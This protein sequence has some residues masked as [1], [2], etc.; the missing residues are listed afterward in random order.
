MIS[1]KCLEIYFLKAVSNPLNGFKPTCSSI[2]PIILRCCSFRPIIPGLNPSN[3]KFLE[4][5]PYAASKIGLPRKSYIWGRFLK[6]RFTVCLTF[7]LQKAAKKLDDCKQRNWIELSLWHSLSKNRTRNWPLVLTS[8]I[9]FNSRKL[10]GKWQDFFALWSTNVD[11]NLNRDVMS[12]NT[13][14][15]WDLLLEASKINQLLSWTSKGLKVKSF[16]PQSC[17]GTNPQYLL[18]Q[19]SHP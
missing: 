11:C 8:L 5:C 19:T 14:W 15:K 2:R 1:K 9:S 6:I 7:S 18:M 16:W 13:F 3:Q 4:L 17:F 10:I 12:L